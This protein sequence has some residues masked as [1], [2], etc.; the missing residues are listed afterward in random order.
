MDPVATEQKRNNARQKLMQSIL[1]IG[2]RAFSPDVPESSRVEGKKEWD[3]AIQRIKTFNLIAALNIL[4]RPG[5]APAWL[6][7]KLMEALTLIP[8]RPDGVRAT[9]E[10]VFAV[11]PSS[12]VKVSEAAVPQKRGANITHEA[13]EMAS[14]LLS[15]CPSSVTP[16][17]WYSSIAPQLLVL[18]D[19]DEGPELTRT[20]SYIIGF[21]IL[22]RKASGA[23][24]TAGW[25]CLAEPLLH[26]IK[27]PPNAQ[28]TSTEDDDGIV[29]LSKEM[30]L[31]KHQDLV[32]ALRR[33][34]SLVVSHPN[35][36]LSKRL[37]SP[38]LPSL[39]ALSTWK[40]AGSELSDKVCGPASELL[41]I[42]LKLAPSPE[43]VL[44]LIKNLGYVGGYSQQSPEWVYK[45]TGK[46]EIGIV[47]AKPRIGG[48]P[49]APQITMEDIE[50]KITK[51]LDLVTTTMSDADIIGAFLELLK[52]W[53]KAARQSRGGN[54]LIKEESEES[55][56]PL[57]QLIEIKTLQS[58]MEKVPDKFVTQPRRILDLVSEILASSAAL[59]EDEDNEEEVTGVAL[60]LL[61]M[62]VTVPGFQKSRVN[63]DTLSLIETSLDKLSKSPTDTGK[64]ANNLRLLLLYRD[65]I[66]DPSESLPSAP[67]DRQIEDRKTYSLAISYITAPD[68]PPPV[69]SEG[70]HLIGTLITSHSPVLDI[71]G[72]LVMLSS[73]IS[74]SDEYIY[75]RIIK[76][77]TL[78]AASHPKAVTND[79]LDQF[80]DPKE[81][82][83][84]DA[85]QRFAE[86]L[87]QVIERLGE[88]FT[89]DLA[90]RVGDGL[91]S[92][93]GRRAHRPKTEARQAREAKLQERKNKEAADA[94]GG[95][96]P[97]FSDPM[98]PE[99]KA[100]NEI[101]ENIVE[102]WESKRG[103]EDIRIRASALGVLGTGMEVNIRGLGV[104]V[105]NTAVE[106]GVSILQMERGVEVG[107]LRRAAVMMVNEFVKGL[108]REG[109]GG[110]GF[111]FGE[112]AREDVMRTLG[113]VRDTDGDGL[114]RRQAGDVL[115]SLEAW[116]VRRLVRRG[117]EE[118]GRR[119]GG[120]GMLRGLVVNP[121][122]RVN[123][124]V[125][126]EVGG[127][128]RIEE[129]E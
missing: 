17:I 49:T 95:A 5:H 91:L 124:D 76:L 101:L 85:R 37:L 110:L 63:P 111:G 84:V 36:G 67:T 98:T 107:I 7:P 11:H 48:T 72:I 61:N 45:E 31:V 89:G 25:K 59:S 78:L 34:K 122:E 80:I 10:F 35:Q 75:L 57:E 119:E 19:G 88:T 12:T 4:V 97:D 125:K 29:D 83:S 120:M 50:T 47:E 105:V 20:A 39:W 86:A 126:S 52:R 21:G 112:K 90:Q 1:D 123:P 103:S 109:E 108:D 2:S 87:S 16:E 70:L 33:L 62:I 8:L 58:M 104:R 128:P 60:S 129:M 18:L 79:L 28:P 44:Y 40:S 69:R 115:E 82:H 13:L 23:P 92:V 96:V 43:L 64:T 68:S 114:V 53:F 42:Y 9:M 65:Q 38:L 22:G 54:V 121:V 32:T 100:R 15:I 102:G 27:P 117:E 56:D 41:K 106:L 74:D 118:E 46:N 81:T 127:R 66:D 55:R 30:V 73:L 94:W 77:Y 6:R 71:P 93:A 116:G 24:G 99:E 3:D 113:W 14:K 51:C 26:A